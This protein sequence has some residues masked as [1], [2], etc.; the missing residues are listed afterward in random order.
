VPKQWLSMAVATIVA[1]SA[2]AACE[3]NVFS[4]KVGDCFNS[5]ETGEISDVAVVDCA[6]AHDAEVYSV[7][8]YPN[9]PSD[10]PGEGAIEQVVNDRCVT[11]FAAYVGKDYASS[12]FERNQ[13]VPTQDGWAQGDHEIICLIVPSGSQ[14]QLT[15]TARGTAR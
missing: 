4:L 11:D 1:I 10:Y 6:Q 12:V 14:A 7:F 2:L 13:L 3:G 15:G 9:A 5:D 8:D